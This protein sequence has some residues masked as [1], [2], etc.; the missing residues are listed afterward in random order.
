MKN[1]ILITGSCG[2]IGSNFIRKT[3]YEKIS[4]ICSI[5]RLDND[6][7]SFNFYQNKS[8]SFYIGNILDKK[9]LDAVF[10]FENPNIVLHLAESKNPEEAISENG[11]VTLNLLQKCKQYNVNKFI[12]GSTTHVYGSTS[13]ESSYLFKEEDHCNPN[14]LYDISKLNSEQIV[15]KFCQ[16]NKL[17]YNI[18][19]ICDV[20]GQRQNTDY[21]IPSL[22]KSLSQTNSCEINGDGSNVREWMHVSDV[23]SAIIFLIQNARENEIYNISSGYEFSFLE[24]AQIVLKNFSNPTLYHNKNS[25]NI[26]RVSSSNDKLKKLGWSPSIKIRSGIEETFQWYNNNKWFLNRG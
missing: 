2:F 19:R 10:K 12:L 7:G 13:K 9:L 8:H 14:T 21:F 17:N 20:Y 26:E 5:D 16:E 24:I 3:I 25:I 4:N 22:L 23:C 1:K 6:S 11:I 18:F 15:R